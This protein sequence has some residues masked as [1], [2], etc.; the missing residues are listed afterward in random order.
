MLVLEVKGREREQ[1]QTKR[2]YMEEWCKAVSE[3][4]GFGHWTCAVS[5]RPSDLHD[6]LAAKAR[7]SGRTGFMA[8]EI[9]PPDFDAMTSEEIRTQFEGGSLASHRGTPQ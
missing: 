5:W 7:A 6:I 3:H 9:N 4:G 2:Q 8:D 1:D